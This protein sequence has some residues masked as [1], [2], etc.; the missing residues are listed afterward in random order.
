M[1]ELTPPTRISYQI[2]F[3]NPLFSV[4]TFSL[5]SSHLE[6]FPHQKGVAHPDFGSR[7]CPDPLW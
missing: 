1:E 3:C 2:R 4:G 7:V 6:S 5:E